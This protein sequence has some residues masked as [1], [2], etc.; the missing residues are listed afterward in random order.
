VEVIL[1]LFPRV[2]HEF[3]RGRCTSNTIDLVFGSKIHVPDAGDERFK[4]VISL[5][6]SADVLMVIHKVGE[7][8]LAIVSETFVGAM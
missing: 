4:L 8:D 5:V 1:P 7:S 2:F 3:S 6:L